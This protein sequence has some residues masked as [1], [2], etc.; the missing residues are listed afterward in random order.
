VLFLGAFDRILAYII[1]SAVL[2]LALAASTL[3]RMPVPVRGWWYP[4]APIVFIALCIL[5]AL[6]I[7]MHDPVPA[8]AGVACVLCG[9]PL[10]RF[11][12]PRRTLEPLISEGS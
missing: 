1:F 12:V 9:W 8:L 7:L 6:L 5:M 2:F 3:F 11:L 10:R 4:I